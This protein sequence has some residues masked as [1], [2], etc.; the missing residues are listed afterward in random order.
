MK[1]KHIPPKLLVINDMA[2]VGR[3]S[4]AV[5]LPVISCCKVQACPIP[6]AVFSNHL[7]F[8]T[9][10]SVD[11]SDHLTNY[12]EHLNL[13]PV[14]FDGILCGFLN[15]PKQIQDL[16]CYF[17]SLPSSIPVFLDPVMGDNGKPYHTVTDDFI[18][19]LKSLLPF[20]ELIT[21]NLTE[22]CLLTG[23]EYLTSFSDSDIK[24]LAHKLQSMGAH[25]VIIT[26]IEQNGQI[27][28]A[29]L[30]SSFSIIRQKKEDI[31]RPGTGDI[32]ISIV[33]A[34]L[35]RSY[36]LKDAASI[37]SS[38]IADCLKVSVDIPVLE[39]V[40]LENCLEQLTHL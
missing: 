34:L 22:A 23:T 17:S 2:G 7:G 20:T 27:A 39:G 21:P 26:G 32:F 1:Q 9:H 31:S 14:N 16:I 25:Q 5:A 18:Q 12:L 15:S 30:D 40:A 35:L 3:C 4:M 11:L 6:T 37:A 24:I 38:F 8:P 10:Y 13:L 28:T 33:S 36:T 19:K 29:V